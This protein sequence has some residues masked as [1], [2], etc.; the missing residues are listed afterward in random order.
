MKIIGKNSVS[1]ILA[2]VLLAFFILTLLHLLYEVLAHTVLFYKFHTGSQ[3]FAETFILGKEVGWADNQWT[4]R[5]SNVLKFRINYPFTSQQLV[6]GFYEPVQI[7]SNFFAFTYFT[8]FF[9]Y[10]FRFFREISSD[11]IFSPAAGKWLFRFGI[12]NLLSAAVILISVLFFF[13]ITPYALLQIV[14]V[15]F[16]GLIVLFAVEFYKKAVELQSQTDLTI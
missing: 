10:A 4:D 16:V 6:T 3:I 2:Y 12:V 15:G 8:L 9:L 5:M 13:Q 1:Q 7:V 14:F 11:R